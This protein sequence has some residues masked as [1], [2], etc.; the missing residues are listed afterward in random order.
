M[1]A[2]QVSRA[3]LRD[4]A[5]RWGSPQAEL[6]NGKVSETRRENAGE[7]TL[8]DLPGPTPPPYSLLA[9]GMVR[10]RGN[11]LVGRIIISSLGQ[12]S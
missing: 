7:G 10:M 6:T 1:L 3:P 11:P 9:F 5:W 4:V 12:I 8:R 2:V